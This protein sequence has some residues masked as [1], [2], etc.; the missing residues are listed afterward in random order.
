[1]NDQEK[2][3]LITRNLQEII[4]EDELKELLK[5][6][7]QI[8]VHWGTTPTGSPHISYY[9]PLLKI[10]D[11]LKAGLNV[12]ILIADLH[13]ALDGIPWEILEKRQKYYEALIPE[14]L[15]RMKVNTKKLEFVKGSTYQLEPKFITDVLKLATKTSIKEATKAASEVV[16]L[17]DNPQLGGIIYPLMQALD[18]EYLNADIQFGGTDQRKILVYAREYLPK[19]GYKPRIELMNFM[20]PG[21][22]GEKMSSSVAGSK[23]DMLD[24]EETISKKINKADCITG[25]ANNGLLAFIKHVIF[26][27]TNKFTIER[28]EKFGG[29]IEYK[30]YEELEKDFTNKNLHPADLKKSLAKELNNLVE[31]IRTQQKIIKLYK[32]AY[33]E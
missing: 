17:G 23:I 27:L 3:N 25:N 6:K 33:S 5:K 10:G 18:E 32:E 2:Y 19:L 30:K 24:S 12:K 16:K 28:P 22:I 15:K 14:M 13:A 9:Y 29:N 20:I 31:P 4:G 11:F 8:T 1:M 7:K 26:P 21:L